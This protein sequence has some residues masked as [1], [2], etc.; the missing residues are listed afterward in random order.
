M[1]ILQKS[2]LI[3]ASTLCMQENVSL[4]RKRHACVGKVVSY[5]RTVCSPRC[6]TPA[7]VI[8]KKL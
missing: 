7:T 1:F 3:F 2:G 8:S 4:Y 5:L 6:L